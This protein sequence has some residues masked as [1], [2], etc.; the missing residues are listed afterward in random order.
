MPDFSDAC[1]W[2]R[3]PWRSAQPKSGCA[4]APSPA[5]EAWERDCLTKL[6]EMG[7]VAADT[8]IKSWR[9]RS[10]FLRH[11]RSELRGSSSLFVFPPHM[12]WRAQ[13]M[14]RTHH[15]ARAL[16][17]MGHRVLY[18]TP[19]RKESFRNYVEIEPRLYLTADAKVIE[20]LT[21]SVILVPSTAWRFGCAEICRWRNNGNTVVYD[22]IDH[23]DERI[24]GV[25]TEATRRLFEY[26][27]SATIDV[28]VASA[29]QLC[30]ALVSRVAP[31]PVTYVPNGVDLEFYQ[32]SMQ[33]DLAPPPELREH[34][35]SA[36]PLIGYFGAIA[37]WLCGDLIRDAAALRSDW[38]FVFI[39][40]QYQEG[41][42]PLPVAR[43]IVTI[44]PVDYCVLPQYGRWFDVAMIP[45]ASGPIARTTSPLK[46]FEYLALGKPVVA[47]TEMLE[48]HGVPSVFHFETPSEFVLASEQAMAT[49]KSR[50][51]SLDV[52]QVTAAADWR[53][54]AASFTGAVS[55]VSH[56]ARLSEQALGRL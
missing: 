11:L 39:G 17:R 47:H 29:S 36:R 41:Q 54:R 4:D 34:I 9:R 27:S 25:N 38:I 3:R 7:V 52:L 23:I 28:A 45:F 6:R 50:A 12:R 21:E 30:N 1:G 48:C 2:L 32:R 31:K 20:D 26:V 43:N 22:Y 53:Q 13:L 56:A 5:R 55:A 14:Q 35:K 18:C 44:P 49:S 16:A 33:I 46:L 10:Q 42:S 40:P 24:T 19:S 51:N 37:P 8:P 15:L